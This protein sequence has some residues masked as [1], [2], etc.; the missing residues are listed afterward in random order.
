V[1][2]LAAALLAGC[3]HGPAQEARMAPPI[4]L[5]PGV[6][7]EL[8]RQRAATI[9]DVS[10]LIELD[11]TGRDDAPGRVTMEFNRA[12]GAGDLVLDFRGRHI[13]EVEANGRV[14]TRARLTADHLVIPAR[15]LRQGHNRLRIEFVAPVAAAGAAI[16][17]FDDVQDN[18]RYLYTLLVPSDAQ[19]LFPVLD[20]PDI[21]A[22]I[23]WEIVAPADWRVLANGPLLRTALDG[24]R[25][26]HVFA[27]TQPISTYT[28]AFAAGPWAVLT[29]PAEGMSDVAQRMTLWT[30]RSRAAEVDADTLLHLNRTGLQWLEQYFA[31]QYPFDKLDL[32]LAPAFPFGGMEHVG[33]IFYNETT[34]VFREPPTLARRLARASTIYHE[35]AHQWFGDL[36]TM[37]WFD[38][39]WLKEGFST[40]MAARM[41]EQLH[42]EADAWKT[43]YLANKPSAYAVDVTA[44]TTPVW[45]ELP[46]LDLAKSAYGAIVY[47]K[48]PAI[49]RQLEFMVGE[50]PFRRGMQLFLRRHAYANANWRE[51]L[52]AISEAAGREL[53]H[54]GAQYILRAGLPLFE[55]VMTA[56]ADGT[57]SELALVQRPAR[58]LPGD[59]GGWWPA[60]LRVRLGYAAGDHRIL[61]VTLTGERT[62]IEA[63]RGLPVPDFVFANDG[64]F[65][66]GIFLPDAR[67]AEWLL[68]HAGGLQ[69]DLL[70]AMAWGALW[71]LVREARLPPGRFVDAALHAW[72]GERD[73]QIAGLL[74]ARARTAISR[75]MAHGAPRD[76][77]VAALE[78]LL[79]ERV[80]DASL[81]YGLRRSALDALLASARS[82]AAAAMLAEYLQGRRTFDDAPL[83]QPSRWAAITR[84]LALQADGATALLAAEVA[85]DSTPEAPRMAFI[86]GAAVP[87]AEGRE[88]LF[89]RYLEDPALNEEW[90]TASLAAFNSD[91]HPGLALPYLRPA[92]DAAEWLRDNRRIFFLPRWLDSFIGGHS[93]PAALAIVDAF[94]AENPAL[95]PDIRRRV[96]QA[97]DDLERAVLVQAA[98]P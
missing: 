65:G 74:L 30:R 25:S 68:L 67:S 90:V 3:A 60:R 42:P 11:V 84:L 2:A 45:Q 64:D 5:E 43:F 15:H 10:Y 49:L 14:A 82:P 87:T 28:A 70:R 96:L 41:Q 33:A 58:E 55:T 23:A 80:E 53:D 44:G 66:Y 27:A 24:G 93:S 78:Q 34:F 19:L 50:E 85:R 98:F 95:P 36:V 77:A 39:L 7:L 12:A 51:L 71:D 56:D 20:Q 75:Y 22:R 9:R 62:V 38:D 69:E 83:G 35:V 81:S 17:A 47:N 32:L 63:A 54:F 4:P 40:F 91:L 52:A 57:V 6:S 88:T 21:K 46:N 59:P 79:M 13:G 31:M 1:T 18:A 92:L 29:H 86:A 16:I 73:E 48:A 8:A 76:S 97:R 89:R 72:A 37:E 61:D 26:R 94:L